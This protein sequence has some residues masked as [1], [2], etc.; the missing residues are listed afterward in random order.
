MSRQGVHSD[1]GS[2]SL[3]GTEQDPEQTGGGS[4]GGLLR[5]PARVGPGTP[6]TCSELSPW[7]RKHVPALEHT[8]A[9]SASGRASPS[10]QMMPRVVTRA[11]DLTVE[12]GSACP[13]S[14]K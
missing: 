10:P 8:M 13:G 12:H 9:G 1:S 2:T 11:S 5:Q 14:P 6:C 3:A 7:A 4:R